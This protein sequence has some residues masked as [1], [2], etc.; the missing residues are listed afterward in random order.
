MLLHGL[1]ML[2][3]SGSSVL[4]DSAFLRAKVAVMKLLKINT[5]NGITPHP[6][7]LGW[8]SLAPPPETPQSITFSRAARY[9]LQP[10][11]TTGFI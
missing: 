8:L 10:I 2:T 6:F 3:I 11:S 4:A 5:E 7:L 1:R 9:N